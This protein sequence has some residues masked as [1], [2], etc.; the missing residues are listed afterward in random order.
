ML[1][2]FVCFLKLIAD[3][4]DELKQC[5]TLN[6]NRGQNGSNICGSP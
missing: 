4:L 2:I 1:Y 6:R 3:L 5:T